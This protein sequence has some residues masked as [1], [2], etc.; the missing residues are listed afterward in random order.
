MV[1]VVAP[2]IADDDEL[3]ANG[4]RVGGAGFG[5]GGLEDESAGR[6][7]F[8]SG[9]CDGLAFAF[10][11]SCILEAKVVRVCGCKEVGDVCDSFA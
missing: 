5:D 3:S 4:G 11:L 10:G 6:E 8:A 9:D 2:T 7:L 1:G